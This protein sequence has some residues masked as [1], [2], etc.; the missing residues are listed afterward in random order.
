MRRKAFIL[1]TVALFLG[2]VPLVSAYEAHLINVTAHVEERFNIIKTMRLATPQEIAESGIDFPGTPNPPAVTDPSRVPVE[3]SV[4]WLATIFASNPHDYP[5]TEVVITDHFAAEMAGE[6]LGSLP[7]DLSIKAHSRGKSGKSSFET[8]YRIT[9]YVTWDTVDNSGWLDPGESVTLTML[10]WT[11]LNPSGRQEYTSP[12]TYT[13]NSGP[14]MKWLDPDG[15]QFSNG[16][17]PLH[18]AAYE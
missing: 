10:V 5:I 17:P 8:Q 16:G 14:M 7:V 15:H 9:W 2:A 18:I 6:Q 11:K 4:V 13:L 3:T 1:A 12:G